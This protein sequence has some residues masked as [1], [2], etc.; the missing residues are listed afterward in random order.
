MKTLKESWLTGE[1]SPSSNSHRVFGAVQFARIYFKNWNEK[2]VRSLWVELEKLIKY[3]IKNGGEKSFI[4]NPITI[5]L[6]ELIHFIPQYKLFTEKWFPKFHNIEL[7]KTQRV[8]AS[9]IY[10][11]AYILKTAAIGRAEKVSDAYAIL[12]SQFNTAYGANGI[13]KN[14]ISQRNR[15]IAKKPRKTHLR[16]LID[17]LL[18]KNIRKN[19]LIILSNIR[20][21]KD[22][23]LLK[24][25]DNMIELWSISKKRKT[26][27]Q[28]ITLLNFK[29]MVSDSKSSIKNKSA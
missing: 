14:F 27:L 4:T 20:D 17:S 18:E 16:K 28:S 25:T 26:F 13:K 29:K 11:A 3:F 19:H 24:E 23:Y 5:L 1:T 8:T 10:L 12:I 22:K 9:E 21:M 2:E 6:S 7:A 15:N